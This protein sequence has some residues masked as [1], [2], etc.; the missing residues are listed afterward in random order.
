MTSK[1]E[2]RGPR[3]H[4]HR[5]L[6]FRRSVAVLLAAFAFLITGSAICAQTRNPVPRIANPLVPTFI[7]PGAGDTTLTVNGTGFVSTSVVNWNGT[8]LTT[9]FVSGDQ[10]TATIP[11][12]NLAAAGTG[13]ITVTT[14]QTSGIPSTSNN[15]FFLV[16]TTVSA[17]NFSQ[18]NTATGGNPTGVAIADF[19]NDGLLDLAITNDNEVYNFGNGQTETGTVE[20]FLG[21]SGGGFAAG[22]T[23]PTG[24]AATITYPYN[25]FAADFNNDGCLDLVTVDQGGPNFKA[26]SISV[27]PGV[28]N[29]DGT[30]AG[31]FGSAHVT[32]VGG[33]D[34]IAMNIGDFNGDGNMDVVTANSVSGN[35]SVLLGNGTGAFAKAVQYATGINPTD[36]TV[37]DFNGDGVPDLAVANNSLSNPTA[38][39]VSIL[40]GVCVTNCTSA[41]N[42]IGNGTFQTQVPYTTVTMYGAENELYAGESPNGITAAAFNGNGILDLATSDAQGWV[43]VLTGAGDGTFD[44]ANNGL[45]VNYSAGVFPAF[46]IEAWDFYDHGLL[47]LATPEYTD[48]DMSIFKGTK[49]TSGLTF[50]AYLVY[51]ALHALTNPDGFGVADFNNDGRLDIVALNESANMFSLLTQYVP[52]VTFNPPTFSF[53][54]VN[55]GQ[56][57]AAKTSTVTNTGTTAVN[58]IVVTITGTNASEF[59]ISSN[60]CTTT[61]NPGATCTISAIMSPITGGTKNAMVTL[62]DSDGTQNLILGGTGVQQITILPTDMETFKPQVVNTTSAPYVA[63]LTNVSLEPL[64]IYSIAVTG[65]DIVNF[66]ES[67]TCPISPATLA[68]GASC[69]I[70]TSFLPTSPAGFS[71]T[72]IIMSSSSTPK[73]AI[74]LKGEG[75]AVALN[76]T[77]L[78]FGTVTVGTSSQMT[79][80]LTNAWT[81]SLTVTS[82]AISGN[83]AAAYTETDN[84]VGTIQPGASCTVTVTF[85][86]TRKGAFAATLTFT[87]SDPTLTQTVSMTGTGSR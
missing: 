50:A 12:A 26:N 34:P 4:I 70:C 51:P 1:I 18:T 6:H 85:L 45:P 10:L 36:V 49:G 64:Y 80:T 75:T 19:N 2:R 72:D 24:P 73:R 44:T 79:V 20:V 22:V 84:C 59:S 28:K 82:V 68:A 71:A 61:L 62:T 87:D 67:N 47:D 15:G 43:S 23:Y 81:T 13:V 39:G 69:T 35:V 14:T 21:Q 38:S 17:V 25:V 55:V 66:P 63:T 53:A 58:N 48:G 27:L 3:A 74:Q 33:I 40:L 31:T 60:T 11:A 76:P 16:A 37:G 46:S 54:S 32:L 42:G 86:P 83:G 8:P 7:A 78:A 41:G 65:A 5:G 9:V 52:T 77:S 57:S 29:S 30:C 56:S